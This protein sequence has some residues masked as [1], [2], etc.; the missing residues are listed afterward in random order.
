M[1]IRR[2]A[3]NNVR[4]PSIRE[5][6]KGNAHAEKSPFDADRIALALGIGNVHAESEKPILIEIHR[7]KVI[8]PVRINDSRALYLKPNSRFGDPFG[9]V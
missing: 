3:Y 7:S 2:P 9:P 8:L 1:V 6:L 4:L 5:T